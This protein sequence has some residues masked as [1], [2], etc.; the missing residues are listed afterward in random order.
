MPFA[1]GNT[2]RK[3]LKGGHTWDA[4]VIRQD[5]ISKAIE[6]RKELNDAL[7]RKAIDDKDVTAIKVVYERTIGA[8]PAAIDITSKGKSM[9]ITFDEAFR[10]RENEQP[11]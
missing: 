9:V 6:R 11:K 3:G 2:L 4:E 5:L 7:L 8:V 1:K 10:N